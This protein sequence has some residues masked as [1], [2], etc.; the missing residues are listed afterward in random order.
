MREI[1]VDS[2]CFMTCTE[3]PLSYVPTRYESNDTAMSVPASSGGSTGSTSSRV[4]M[5]ASSHRQYILQQQQQRGLQLQRRKT[6]V[7]FVLDETFR[8]SSVPLASKLRRTRDKQTAPAV[9]A[10][11]PTHHGQAA[12]LALAIRQHPLKC[13]P[14]S[15]LIKTALE[16]DTKISQEQNTPRLFQGKVKKSKAS[17]YITCSRSS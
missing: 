3:E 13:I 9:S 10:A 8:R 12:L 6:I 14:R 11:S 16:L 15:D 4:A 7:K 5:V 1:V 17:G 2:F